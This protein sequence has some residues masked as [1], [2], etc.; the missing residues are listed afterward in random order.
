MSKG[1]IG[2]FNVGFFRY[3]SQF[4]GL[5]EQL[6]AYRLEFE[7]KCRTFDVEIVSAGLVDTV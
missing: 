1:L 6:E 3:W 5:K 7:D 2:V 4:P